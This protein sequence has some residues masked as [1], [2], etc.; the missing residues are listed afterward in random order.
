M[1]LAFIVRHNIVRLS[2]CLVA[3]AL[4]GCAPVATPPENKPLFINQADFH[5]TELSHSVFAGQ[6]NGAQSPASKDLWQ[7]MR[8]GFKLPEMNAAAVDQQARRFASGRYHLQP[9][10][11]RASLYLFYIIQE[12][13]ARDM[14]TEIAL[15]PFIESSYSPLQKGTVHHAGI[16]GIMPAAGKHLGLAQTAFKD[17]RR[18]ILRST[19]GALD[20]LQQLY[21]IFGDWQLAIV[22]YNWGSGNVIRAVAKAKAQKLTATYE[23]ISF[24][25]AVRDYLVWVA[26]YKDIV[27]HPERYGVSLP[28]LGNYPYFVVIDVTRDI[29]VSVVLEL[30]EISKEDFLKLNP[31]FNRPVILS[32]PE[33]KILLPYKNTENFQNNLKNYSRP[34]TTWKKTDPILPVAKKKK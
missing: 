8:D 9:S 12:L 25:K 17:E 27:M 21:G 3:L 32:A 30:A 18:D 28:P 24:P 7:V 6:P 2:A 23:N 31:S 10:L 29:D 15:I 1:A 20:Y 33:Q 16:W 13:R 5:I 11:D 14:P 4:S 26:A 22:A 19:Q 34:L